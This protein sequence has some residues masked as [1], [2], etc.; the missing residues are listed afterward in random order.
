M[1]ALQARGHSP[2]SLNARE[3]DPT[4]RARRG[5]TRGVQGNAFRPPIADI[6]MVLIS[7]TVCRMFDN[8]AGPVNK[9]C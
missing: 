3:T 7:K 6:A 8:G 4:V 5:T 2:I 9:V 1:P